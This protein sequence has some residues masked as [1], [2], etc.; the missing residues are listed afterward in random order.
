MLSQAVPF[1]CYALQGYTNE[2]VFDLFSETFAILTA[3]S[4]FLS[5]EHVPSPRLV[6][7]PH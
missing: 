5:G 3:P 1:S 2:M 7:K 6:S 4:A